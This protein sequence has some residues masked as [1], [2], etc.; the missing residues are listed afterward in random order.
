M[1]SK[2]ELKAIVDE[3]KAAI[4]A[5]LGLAG[6][7]IQSKNARTALPHVNKLA[8]LKAGLE[9]AI[10]ALIALALVVAAGL[11]VSLFTAQKTALKNSANAFDSDFKCPAKVPTSAEALTAYND[12]KTG[13]IG[14]YCKSL[15]TKA[16]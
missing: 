9:E 15:M 2:K 14:C 13:L 8:T 10:I 5:A 1:V 6:Q 11:S 7:Y 4:Q 12:G 16:P 3:H